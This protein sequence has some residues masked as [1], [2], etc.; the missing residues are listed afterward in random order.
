[1]TLALDGGEEVTG[2]IVD[3]VT[4]DGTDSACLEDG[5]KIDVTRI[6]GIARH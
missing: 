6:V 4:A 3:V 1:V 2:R 5:A